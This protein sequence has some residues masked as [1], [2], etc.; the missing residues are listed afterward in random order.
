MI[1]GAQVRTTCSS[2]K[3]NN[4]ENFLR[5]L[6]SSTSLWSP[7]SRGS[8]PESVCGRGSPPAGSATSPTRSRSPAPWTTAWARRTSRA[9]TATSTWPGTAWAASCWRP[10]LR[11]TLTAQQVF[12]EEFLLGGSHWHCKHCFARYR[13]SWVV[14]SWPVWLPRERLPSACSHRCRRAGRSHHLFCV[15]VVL[16]LLIR[17]GEEI[18]FWNHFFDREWKESQEAANLI[19]M[20]GR[21]PVHIINDANHGQVWLPTVTCTEPFGPLCFA[22]LE[23]FPFFD[24]R[25]Q[26]VKS[27]PLSPAKI[28]RL[29]SRSRRHDARSS[30]KYLRLSFWS[31]AR[32]ICNLCCCLHHRPIWGSLH[33]RGGGGLLCLFSSPLFKVTMAETTMENLHDYTSEFLV[34][35]AAASAMENDGSDSSPWM[36]R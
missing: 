34:P 8:C 5:F 17:P 15:Q 16:I 19:G 4:N 21:F 2:K 1:P 7:R 28:S 27:Q 20:P 35:F 32:Q 14:P 10:G 29:R 31:G 18:F 3:N 26:A 33:R 36:I 23:V 11:T 13:S 12:I 22:N 6:A 24:R 30:N 25:W 9:C